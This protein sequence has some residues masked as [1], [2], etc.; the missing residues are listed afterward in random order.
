L[1]GHLLPRLCFKHCL[2]FSKRIILGCKQVKM[3]FFFIESPLGIIH[4]TTTHQPH[5]ILDNFVAPI[6]RSSL[7]VCIPFR[8]IPSSMKNA[9]L[10]GKGVN[11]GPIGSL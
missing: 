8:S 2:D 3:K 4:D 6:S 7:T 11:P 10:E 1:I 9:I 5:E